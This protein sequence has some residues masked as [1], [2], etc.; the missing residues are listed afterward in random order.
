MAY[1]ATKETPVGGISEGTRLSESKARNWEKRIL[2]LTQEEC[3][4][5]G[6]D[7]AETLGLIHKNGGHMERNGMRCPP[8]SA[9]P[10]RRCVLPCNARLRAGQSACG[11]KWIECYPK[12]SKGFRTPQRQDC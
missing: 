11:V 1:E 12:E 10:I 6:P 2:W 3:I 8:R 7:V 4:K 9:Y 5:A